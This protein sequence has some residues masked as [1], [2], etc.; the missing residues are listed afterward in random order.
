[1]TRA[2]LL[3]L[4]LGFAAAEPETLR[5]GRFGDVRLVRGAPDPT[6]VVLLLS[7]GGDALARGLAE[8]GALVVAIDGARYGKSLA[9]GSDRCAYPA[10]ELEG[11]SQFVQKQLGRPSYTVPYVV[12]VG[13]GATLARGALDQAPPNTFRAALA[14]GFDPALASPRP[15]C[16]KHGTVSLPA[17]SWRAIEGPADAAGEAKLEAA[18]AE[19]VA[20]SAPPRP[21][22]ADDVSDLPL[23]AVAPS[24]PPS[25]VLA[26]ILSGDGGWASLDREIGD[27]LA[28]RGIP[29][30][31][32]D[33]LQYFWTRRTP[34]ES[35]GA[36]ERVLL[37]AESVWPGRRIA[38]IGYS[39]GADVL[40]FLASR[41]PPNLRARIALVAL[42]G[43]ERSAE[44]E[45]HISDWLHSDPRPD[46]LPIA[47]EVAKLAGLR[48]LCVYGHDEDVSV[49]RDLPAE[50][51]I[52]DERPGSHHFGGDYEA[53][54][55][56]IAQE[57]AR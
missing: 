4:L 51:A 26:V 3:A 2:L 57:L 49:C 20:A 46:A 38:L 39:R 33:S 13:A 48:V 34:D 11:L 8:R 55:A 22:L 37:H 35:A 40:P 44:F 28:A 10:G 54:G 6:Q 16:G 43:P 29:V 41:L 14:L 36:L 47:P 56:R 30:I 12:G 18:F 53:I 42:V 45:F 15:F 25:D 24:G 17:T 31:G 50:L 1:V 27:A 23:I 5:F 21:A 7:N 32:F 19:L 9:T 52:R